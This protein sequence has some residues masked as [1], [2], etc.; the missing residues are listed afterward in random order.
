M[1]RRYASSR[2]FG[3]AVVFVL[4]FGALLGRLA[5]VQV[6]RAAHWKEAAQ[7]AS[8]HVVDEPAERG[9]ILGSKGAVLARSETWYRVGV[10]RPASW[11]VDGDVDGLARLLGLDTSAVR[12]AVAADKNHVVL[13]EF[14]L[15]ESTRRALESLGSIT[16][17]SR[18]QR[19]HTNGDM[20]RALLGQVNLGGQGL[21]GL[22]AVYDDVLAGT[23]GK[24][25]ELRDAKQ[26]VRE[27]REVEAPRHGPDIVL[28]IDPQVQSLV[29]AQLDSARVRAEADLAQ[30][31]VMDPWTGDVIAM[32]QSPALPGS[33]VDGEDV[34]PWR[35]VPVTDVF[36][37]GSVFKLFSAASLL[38]RGVCDT[39]TTFD[40]LRTNKNQRRSKKHFEDG[41]FTIRDVNP[42]GVV[43][44]R[45]AFARSS[46]IVLATAT[47]NRLT[48]D[49][50]FGDL[51]SYGF[52]R[53]LGMGFP[54]ETR[55]I[56]RAPDHPKWSARTRA[57]LAIGQEVGVNLMQLAA[58]AS[59]MLGDG[60]LRR[61]RLVRELR[62]RNGSIEEVETVV[63]R[64][65]IVAPEV[66]DALR[67]M[68]VDVV[69]E[70]YGTGRRARLD[71][72]VV[73]GKT[74][75]AQVAASTGGY[76]PGVYNPTFVGFAPASHPQLVVVIALHRAK[77]TDVSGGGA[78][79]PAFA[80]LL[81]EIASTTTLLDAGVREAVEAVA[82]VRAPD[83]VGRHVDEIRELAARAAWGTALPELPGVGTIVGQLP[84]P[85]TPM[86]PDA[87]MQLAYARE[88][89]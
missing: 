6:V 36:E 82:T 15:E 10:S 81:G 31:V 61:P 45:H 51:S 13:G 72:I 33:T 39:S 64:R 79:A 54:G 60:T 52:G 42:V 69:G 83:L 49:E 19:V 14:F 78:A 57:T 43:S 37:P 1:S 80:D 65:N 32:A 30:A 23:P 12:R 76:L 56:L 75:T 21:T 25:V 48:S 86:R 77:A 68:C 2:F 26:N 27:R 88:G 71:G 40:G 50:L 46:N 35:V 9:R 7:R 34:S 55:G 20:A 44:L 4:A 59:A 62:H 74:G 3:V 41:N 63:V 87:I 73:G 84:L 24:V 53:R 70:P 28:T 67:A 58:G 38:S 89:R 47:H 66:T 85:G 17:T 22:E 5:W 11:R 16:F 8:T 18:V 29:E